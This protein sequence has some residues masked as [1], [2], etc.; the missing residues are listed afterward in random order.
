[1][2][3]RRWEY[4]VGLQGGRRYYIELKGAWVEGSVW[5][6]RRGCQW[7]ADGLRDILMGIN[8]RQHRQMIHRKCGCE[9]R[10]KAATHARLIELVLSA[11]RRFEN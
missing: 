7:V 1:M 10:R 3:E 2:F 4:L 5:A 11:N 6:Q 9:T 8:A